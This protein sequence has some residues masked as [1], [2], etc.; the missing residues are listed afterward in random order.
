MKIGKYLPSNGTEEEIFI[1]EYCEICKHGMMFRDH[2]V[3]T[4]CK[5]FMKAFITGEYV[6]QWVYSD[7]NIPICTRF[8]H[9][10]AKRPKS[11]PKDSNQPT[12][13]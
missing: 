12:L 8:I 10:Q 1:G 5:I 6:N 11:K 2:R 7:D 4:S 3:K 9:Y 13:F